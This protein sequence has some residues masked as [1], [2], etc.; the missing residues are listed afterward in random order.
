M[1]IH[2]RKKGLGMMRIR[3][4]H[5]AVFFT[6]GAGSAGCYGQATVTGPNVECRNVEVR[7]HH[8][9]EVCRTRCGDE[10]CR[11]HCAEQERWAHEHRCWV[12]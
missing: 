1:E 6:L 7:S 8:D 12:D 10:G 11:T 9:V 2:T 3:R 4:M 5:A